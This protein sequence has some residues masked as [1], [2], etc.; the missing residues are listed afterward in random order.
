MWGTEYS[1]PL[2]SALA[3]LQP[4]SLWHI[5]HPLGPLGTQMLLSI[6]QFPAILPVCLP[7]LARSLA[8]LLDY[9]RSYATACYTTSKWIA[10]AHITWVPF[11]SG[12][13]C[14]SSWVEGVVLQW[15]LSDWLFLYLG[16][17]PLAAHKLIFHEAGQEAHHQPG[18]LSKNVI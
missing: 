3:L 6:G 14:F 17:A 10:L 4:L 18:I 5:W 15:P 2:G 11:K 13:C 16:A 1:L 9:S 7:S 8:S 12:G